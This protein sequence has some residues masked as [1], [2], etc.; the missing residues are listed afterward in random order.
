[1]GELA[2]KWFD[3]T[4]SKPQADTLKGTSR[5]PISRI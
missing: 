3:P 4:G 1:V 5:N 2:A